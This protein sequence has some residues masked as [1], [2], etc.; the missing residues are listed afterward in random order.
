MSSRILSLA[1]GS[2]PEAEPLTMVEAAAAGGWRHT[3]L[4]I[5]PDKNW[6]ADT[7]GKIRNALEHHGMTAVDVEV[8]WIHPGEHDPDHDRVIAWGAEVGARAALIV[9]SEPD[10]DQTRKRYER[11]CER[12]DK[13]G[14]R[15][16]LEFLPITEV[17]TLADAR[18][19]VETVGHP[20]GGLLID[21]IHL[22]RSGGTPADLA[23]VDPKWF[24]YAQFCDGR[25]ALSDMTFERILEDAVDGRD[26]A[27]KGD[28]PL[29]DLLAQLP[30]NIPLSMEIRSKAWRDRYP[31]VFERAAEMYTETLN[32]F[33]QHDGAEMK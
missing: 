27:G 31:D 10:P 15:A 28:L 11:L 32:W 3:G 17:K 18:A 14:I 8:I 4:W 24:P 7:A 22:A 21:P 23:A 5:E 13:E 12:A 29:V 1:A 16:V 30:A 19:I 25:S 33:E 26:V 9:S 6:H 20:A 2:L